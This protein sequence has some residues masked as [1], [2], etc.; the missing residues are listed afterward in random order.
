VQ[1]LVPPTWQSVLAHD[2]EPWADAVLLVDTAVLS[3]E[4]ALALISENIRP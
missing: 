2:Y 4:Q 1:G 3:I